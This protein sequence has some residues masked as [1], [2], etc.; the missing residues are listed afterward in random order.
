MS[1]RLPFLFSLFGQSHRL[2]MGVVNL[3]TF[4]EEC[5]RSTH[6]AQTAGEGETVPEW[7]GASA[8]SEGESELALYYCITFTRSF[9][10]CLLLYS[11]L[12][13]IRRI[14]LFTFLLFFFYCIHMNDVHYI[15]GP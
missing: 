7:T 11:T 10:S 14:F 8:G 15:F 2:A 6:K 3:V 9:L 13:V 12:F 1:H 4:A 5:T